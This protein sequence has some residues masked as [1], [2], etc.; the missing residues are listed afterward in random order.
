[1]AEMLKAGAHDCVMKTRLE[2]LAPAVKRELQAALERRTRRQSI[3]GGI[4]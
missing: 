1:V 3:L 4:P 2:R